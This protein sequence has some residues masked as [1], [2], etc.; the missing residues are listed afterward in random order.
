MSD[1]ELPEGVARKQIVTIGTVREYV[2]ERSG[3]EGQTVSEF[4]K[5]TAFPDDWEEVYHG[6][7]DDEVVRMKVTPEVDEMVDR[8]TGGRVDKGEVIAYYA[9][10]DALRSGDVESARE[11]VEYIPEVLWDRMEG[12]V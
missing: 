8:M 5:E 10:L 7:S 6:Y 2:R 9:L 3:E 4:L 1:R 11:L 12:R